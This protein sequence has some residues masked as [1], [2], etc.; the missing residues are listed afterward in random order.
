MDCLRLLKEI[1]L[2]VWLLNPYGPLPGEAWRETRYAM[3]G[4]IL[5]EH[6][7][8]VVWWTASFC[9]HSKHVRSIEPP[10]I[11]IN[12]RFTI[13]LVPTPAY[14]K[15]IGFARLRF[16]AM[17]ALRLHWIASRLSPPQ[18]IVSSDATMGLAYVASS[19]AERFHANLIYDIIDLAP[20][21]FSGALPARVR[22]HASAIFSPLYAIRSRN[23][24][25]ATAVT[26]VCDDYLLPARRAKTTISG[27]RLLTVYWGVDLEVFRAAQGSLDDTCAL[28]EQLCKGRDDVF[29]IYAGTLG[30][31]YDVD[32]LLKA[33]V[34][35]QAV[36]SHVKILIAG[37]GP[38]AGDIRLYIQQNKLYNVKM[39]GEVSFSE[40]IKIYQVCD[41]GLNIY[42][43]DSP[44]AMPIKVF[45]Y[46]AAGLP[47]VN[48]IRGF[49]ER[50]LEERHIGMQYVAGDP[51]SL[52]DALVKLSFDHSV[53]REMSQNAF[54]AASEFDSKNQYG[55]FAK[56]LESL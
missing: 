12:P 39:L 40:L 52:A 47:I 56:M 37:G 7:H 13:R 41:V 53:R 8:D 34:L 30:V 19:L 29:A 2:K 51:E 33:A 17:F 10:E 26:A 27:D 24:R 21:V 38:R 31:L 42:G 22:G 11:V 44:V 20:E 45:D 3:L 9:H 28:A 50:F 15:H 1:G 43:V 6:G 49:L 23:F 55:N 18:T 16:E 32:A 14:R 54:D 36:D 35:L 48:S 5:A 25:K 4:R 46:F